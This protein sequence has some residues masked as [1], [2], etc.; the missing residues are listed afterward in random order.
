[1]HNYVRDDAGSGFIQSMG[2]HEPYTVRAAFGIA[3]AY[4][5]FFNI[6]SYWGLRKL[7]RTK[8]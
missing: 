3:M 6:V 8:S 5:I 1:M 2:I 7:Y 4:F